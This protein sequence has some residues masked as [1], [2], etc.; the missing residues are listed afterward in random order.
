[1]SCHG[2]GD[3]AECWVCCEEADPAGGAVAAPTGCACRGSAGCAHLGCLVDVARHKGSRQARHDAWS[4]C[5]TCE[6][7]Y[8]GPLAVGLARTR[9]AP[10]CGPPEDPTSLGWAERLD[11]LA[12]LAV[13]LQNAGDRAGARPLQEELLVAVRRMGGGPA[14][15]LDCMITTARMRAEMREPA[16]ALSLLEEALPACQRTLGDEHALTLSCMSLLGNVREQLGQLAAARAMHEEAVGALRRAGARADATATIRA[17][18]QLG[19]CLVTIGDV[20]AGFALEEEA[21]AT[22]RRV[23]GEAHHMAQDIIQGL[24]QGRRFAAAFPPGACAAGTLVGLGGRPEL[25]GK[26]GRVVGFDS[27]RYR[28]H[29]DGN[30]W[31]FFKPLGVKPANL[32]PVPGLQ[33][34]PGGRGE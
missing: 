19:G 12:H 9:Y 34:Q 7:L 33:A 4:K 26:K 1:M 28:V 8:T 5:P 25:N 16:A 2:M 14:N 10:L 13:A 24:A 32:V 31:A 23:L 29:L 21:A 3:A 30:N 18:G 11:A 15:H 22:A 20:P 17:I 27:G 6:Q